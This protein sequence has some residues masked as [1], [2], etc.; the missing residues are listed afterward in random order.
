MD[1][2]GESLDAAATFLR[3]NAKVALVAHGDADGIC[4]TAILEE[5]L[6]EIGV[7]TKTQHLAQ[8][9]TLAIA[10]L[11]RSTEDP[12]VFVDTGSSHLNAIA[13]HL[14]DRPA[15]ILDH[16]QPMGTAPN[17]IVCNPVLAG[18]DGTR[19]TS[20][21]GIAYLVAKRLAPEVAAKFA[22]VAIIGAQAD[23]QELG[24]FVGHNREILLAAIGASQIRVREGARLYG[25]ESKPVLD[26]VAFSYD[27][28]IPGVTRDKGGA[29]R[30]LTQLNIRN[31]E[32]RRFAD[33]TDEERARLDDALI[34]RSPNPDARVTH[35]TILAA[36]Q[37]PLRDTRECAT[38]INACGR[39]GHAAL[40]V[41]L[42]RGNTEAMTQAREVQRQYRAAVQDAHRWLTE[43]RQNNDPDVK[44]LEGL[45][46]VRA[47]ERIPPD[48]AGTLCSV[49]AKGG[50]VPQGTI[51]VCL[52]RNTDGTAT[53]KASARAVQPPVDLAELMRMAAEP[54]G[55]EGGGHAVAAGAIIPTEAE[56]AF[57]AAVENIFF[58]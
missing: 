27:L 35:Y 48:L 25:I 45:V 20:T 19:D 9:S 32:R 29:K 21:A 14:G 31:P 44:A 49:L 4:A 11:A 18:L 24:A 55:G 42:L 33:L 15:L 17:A 16:H 3:G 7:E 39:L 43:A 53:T 40:A 38:L 2:F 1:P 37:G 47:R 46:L 5:V 36:P 30:L 51:V 50:E 28:R 13:R 8:I 22:P 10:H 56:E 34:E 6:A 52:A 54:I 12:V 26:L 57:L 58:S 41:K 23:N